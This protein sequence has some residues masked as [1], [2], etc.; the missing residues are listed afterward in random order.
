MNGKL[1]D[2]RFSHNRRRVGLYEFLGSGCSVADEAEFWPVF[3]FL[4]GKINIGAR[5]SSTP[6]NTK[7]LCLTAKR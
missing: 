2:G 6:N 5:F 7:L 3:N 1:R 4:I